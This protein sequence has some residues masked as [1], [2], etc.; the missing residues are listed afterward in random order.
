MQN[1]AINA[2]VPAPRIPIFAKLTVFVVFVVVCLCLVLNADDKS[3]DVV[4]WS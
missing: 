2:M 1:D 3:A 4:H